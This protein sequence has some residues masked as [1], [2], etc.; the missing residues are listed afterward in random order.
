[1]PEV[2]AA[3]EIEDDR[4]GH[5]RHHLMG[6]RSDR[7]AELETLEM[8]H[9]TVGG[10]QSVGAAPGQADGVDPVDEI[11]RIECVGLAGAGSAPRTSTPAT[12]PAG[13]MIAVVPVCQPRPVRW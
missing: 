7:H 11:A 13:A 6:F 1:M 12:A 2:A 5:D 3:T 10:R 9:D 4:G 8:G